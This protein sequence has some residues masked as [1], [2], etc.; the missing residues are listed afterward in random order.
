MSVFLL[1][2]ITFEKLLLVVFK[3]QT[4]LNESFLFNQGH[5]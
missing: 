4:F 5:A 3:Y 2:F 1:N